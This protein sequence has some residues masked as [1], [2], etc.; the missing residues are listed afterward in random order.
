MKNE[1]RKR[2]ARALD[3]ELSG[4]RVSDDLARRV[5]EA[6]EKRAKAIGFSTPAKRRPELGASAAAAC[7]AVMLLA[8]TAV[9]AVNHWGVFDFLSDTAAPL[10]VGDGAKELVRTDLGEARSE[11]V[12][13]TLREL[14]YDGKGLYFTLYAEPAEDEGW[15]ASD[16]LDYD[17]EEMA[18]TGDPRVVLFYCADAVSEQVALLEQHEDVKQEGRGVVFFYQGVVK[19]DDGTAPDTLRGEV[20]YREDFNQY[21]NKTYAASI[22]F[23]VQAKPG[24]QLVLEPERPFE[25]LDIEDILLT[26][27]D[28]ADYVKITYRSPFDADQ[29]ALGDIDDEA[30][31]YATENGV[32]IHRLRECSGMKDAM[33]ITGEQAR[34][35]GRRACPVCL[36][37]QPYQ[38]GFTGYDWWFSL[39][40]D[41]GEPIGQFAYDGFCAED[42]ETYTVEFVIQRQEMRERYTLRAEKHERTNYDPQK[43]AF[44]GVH[45][46]PYDIPCAARPAG[47]S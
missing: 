30:T 39:L 19:G 47:R 23:E 1:N 29:Q 37:A 36:S 25:P 16:W 45:V 22:P 8:A 28:V 32:F 27:T 43:R 18:R 26:H 4:L 33:A 3:S 7:V 13:F 15:L 11:D 5:L 41:K 14:M 17:E 24:V 35:Q 44:M 12:V 10:A 21:T 31:Y 40:D 6:P 42:N 46:V 9:A 2:L 34:A 20:V 38:S